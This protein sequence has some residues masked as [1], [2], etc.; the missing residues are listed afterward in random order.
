MEVMGGGVE[1]K[2]VRGGVEVRE[3]GS[4]RGGE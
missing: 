2:A 4:R 3:A 1:A